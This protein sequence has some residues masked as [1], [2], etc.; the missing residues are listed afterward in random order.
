MIYGKTNWTSTTPINTTNLNKIEDGIYQ[1]NKINNYSTNEQV[2]GTWVDGKPLY[3][4]VLSTG[5]L[6][7]NGILT[8]PYNVDNLKRILKV[9]GIAYGGTYGLLLPASNSISSSVINVYINYGV[10]AIE[11]QTYS[12]R[13]SYTEGYITIEYTKTTD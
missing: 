10:K 3:R 2:I 5:T 7:N 13:T 4:K 9:S 8:I 12:D 6:P 11:I 1:A